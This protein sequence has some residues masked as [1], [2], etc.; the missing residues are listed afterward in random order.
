MNQQFLNNHVIVQPTKD[1][2]AAVMTAELLTECFEKKN[3]GIRVMECQTRINALSKTMNLLYKTLEQYRNAPSDRTLHT[4]CGMLSRTY[5]FAG[6]TRAYVASPF[7][8][9]S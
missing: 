5:K 7:G 9:I 6:F 3:T 1:T 8:N 4:L 2:K